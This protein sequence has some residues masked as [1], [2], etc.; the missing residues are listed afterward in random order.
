MDAVIVN[1]VGVFC[2][3]ERA[4]EIEDY[5]TAHPIPKSSMRIS[6]VVESIRISGNMLVRVRDSQ[7]TSPSFWN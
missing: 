7:L 4:Q 1:S 5:F 2:T 6:Q 3:L